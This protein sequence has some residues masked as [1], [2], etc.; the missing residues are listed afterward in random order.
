[1]RNNQPFNKWDYIQTNNKLLWK[2]IFFFFLTYCSEQYQVQ[3]FSSYYVSLYSD[4]YL[5]PRI[6]YHPKTFEFLFLQFNFKVI[7]HQQPKHPCEF[8]ACFRLTI[9]PLTVCSSLPRPYID[10]PIILTKLSEYSKNL[11]RTKSLKIKNL[12]AKDS[13]FFALKGIKYK[14]QV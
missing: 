13:K 11:R 5:Y 1:M 14:F 9:C 10:M 3:N 2:Q 6:L 8:I 4:L 7:L 12:L